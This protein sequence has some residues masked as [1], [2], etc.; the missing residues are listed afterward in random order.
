MTMRPAPTHGI[1]FSRVDAVVLVAG[2]GLTWALWRP[3]GQFAL[4]VPVTLFHFLLFCNVF[5]VRR[6][7]EL[8]WAGVFVVNFAAWALSGDFSWWG[9]LGVQVPVTLGI[10]VVEVRHP[11]YHGVF[12]RPAA[13]ATTEGP[14]VG[15]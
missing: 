5:R 12:S 4:L 15:R 14:E 7:V 1:R 9:V 2:A 10:L 3:L 6:G 11:R 13:A 8:L